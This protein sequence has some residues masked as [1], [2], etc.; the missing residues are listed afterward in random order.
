MKDAADSKPANP[1]DEIRITAAST[2]AGGVPSVL[3]TLKHARDAG[4]MR[5]VTTLLQVNQKSGFQCPGCAWPDPE[6]RGH[7]EFCEQGAKVV[8]DEITPRRL[9]ADFFQTHSITSLRAQSDHW[10]NQ[11][12][13]LTE[14]LW[15]PPGADHY[16]AIDW[17]QAFSLIGAELRALP[18]PDA[19]IFYASGR[20]SNEAA[21]LY[22]LFA[23]AFGTN[24]LPDSSNMC[25]ESS[26]VALKSQLG[27]A[28]GTVTLEDFA[29]ADL[30]FII[31][32][33][34]GTNHPRMLRTLQAAARRGSKIIAINPLHEAG[35][36][37]FKDPQE[38]S[39]LLGTGTPLAHLFLQV[40][41]SGDVALL[42]G[43]IKAVIAHAEQ[44]AGAGLDHDF[45]REHT[46][47]FDAYKAALAEVPWDD[48]EAQAGI[49]RAQI[50]TAAQY[51]VNAKRVICCWA[52]GLTQHP[53]A[54]ATIHE[55]VHLLMIGGHL[56]RAGAG[57]C[58][59]RGHSNVQGD[60]TMGITV[61]PTAEF[62][63]R[64]EHTFAITTPRLPGYHVVAAIKA[65]ATD[66]AKVFCGLGG[67]FLAASPDTEF[68]AAALQRCRLSVQISTKL[69]RSHLITGAQALILPCLG[70]S[71][72]DLQKS[73]PQFVTTENSMGFISRSAGRL[74]PPS[75]QVRSEVAIIAGIAR[76]SLGDSSG[77]AWEGYTGNY[78][79]IRA[80]IETVIPGFER[81]N[82]RMQSTQG[83]SLPH[84]VRDARRFDTAHGRALFMLHSLPSRRLGDAEF[85]LMTIR[86]HDQFNTTVYG[87]DDRYRGI[88]G[89]RRVVL[90]NPEDLQTHHLRAG[91]LVD[92][93]SE[94]NG[95]VRR[96]KQFRL[97][98]YDIPQR[99]LAAYYPETNVLISID[100]LAAESHTPASK[101]VVVKL[102]SDTTNIN[103]TLP[104]CQE[105]GK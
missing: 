92:L 40:R 45:I 83:F 10:L 53:E 37:R 28:K 105:L 50:H 24:N 75:P 29:Q 19:A 33:N 98:P 14:P 72:E 57:A 20:T 54:V 88:Y 9:T 13:R 67:N 95:V 1:E 63:Q 86:S 64:L 90:I 101:F 68:T 100:N 48:I 58:P 99:C 104:Q 35:L 25:H 8:T 11:Q 27:S 22:Q 16:R 78:N 84:A 60:R 65:M 97:V 31:G 81:Y 89:G 42:K 85:T 61:A 66:Q 30:I 74:A 26:S 93:V 3:A 96:A 76:H 79:L 52:M 77:I 87:L 6:E 62:L 18:S 94:F 4:L 46:H 69:N 56:G 32:Q 41:L 71:E 15:R 103:G 38:I 23:R 82:E 44:H 39:G 21:F 34:P 73:V 36:T 47:G 5:S 17:E 51:Y 70:R 55:V 91:E 102:Q 7:A 80:A 2:Y 49:T 12:G 43:I 59:V